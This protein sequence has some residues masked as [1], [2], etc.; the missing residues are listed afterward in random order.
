MSAKGNKPTLTKLYKSEYVRD[1]VR[2][3]LTEDFN[4]TFERLIKEL[5]GLRSPLDVTAKANREAIKDM[6]IENGEK[7]E[8]IND[9]KKILDKL[10]TWEENDC[11][12][13]PDYD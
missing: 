6:F 9:L 11:E 5:R 8:T 4:A 13:N 3:T 1:L 7:F 10:P 12:N 2:D